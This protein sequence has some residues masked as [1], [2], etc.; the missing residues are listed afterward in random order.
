MLVLVLLL[1]TLASPVASTSKKGI[2]LCGA[3]FKCGDTHALSD[4][5]WWYD[6]NPNTA[7]Y[8]NSH[9]KKHVHGEYVPMIR[10]E[11]DLWTAKVNP[12]SK[13]LLGFNEPNGQRHSLTPEK[14]ASLW[15]QLEKKY[16]KPI[17]VGPG[18][19]SCDTHPEWCIGWYEKFF[20]ACQNCRVNRIAVHAYHCEPYKIMQSLEKISRHFGGKKLWLTEFA[21]ETSYNIDDN[22]R[23]MQTLVPLLEKAWFIE[24]YSWYCSRMRYSDKNHNWNLL[25]MD[26]PTLSRIGK[27]YN[28]IH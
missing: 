24:R 7:D 26:S 22:I 10:T 20:K 5:T 28:N 27:A 15:K 4:T 11:Q 13:H 3:A 9:C 16:P 17:L 6:W 25:N 8:Y 18:L 14:A 2:A 19:T 21:C 23:F 12:N 1:V